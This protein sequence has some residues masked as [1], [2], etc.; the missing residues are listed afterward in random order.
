MEAETTSNNVNS[1]EKS[2]NS[3]QLDSDHEDALVI[4]SDEEKLESNDNKKQKEQ[5]KKKISPPKT[6]RFK[7]P[8]CAMATSRSLRYTIHLRKAHLK[9]RKQCPL[10]SFRA[11]SYIKLKEH[12]DT[13]LH[14]NISD[15]KNR[16]KEDSSSATKNY[17]QI[18]EKSIKKNL[19]CNYCGK[20]IE[21][22]DLE[23]H[24]KTSHECICCDFKTKKPYMLTFHYATEHIHDNK[25][26]FCDVEI[27]EEDIINVQAHLKSHIVPE[28]LIKSWVKCEVCSKYF[29]YLNISKHLTEHISNYCPICWFGTLRSEKLTQHIQTEHLSDKFY[30]CPHCGYESNLLQAF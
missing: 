1:E 8:F 13:T 26:L 27:N 19:Q 9:E 25:C 22:A 5:K 18:T 15:P 14:P 30:K 28:V 11:V 12:I 20:T 29:R 21:S 2:P 23:K 3:I 16:F 7:C 24:M 4:I 17:S 6:A 10:C